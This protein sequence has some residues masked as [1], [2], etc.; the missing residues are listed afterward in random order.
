MS[1][2]GPVFSLL[3]K[4]GEG[5]DGI[6]EGLFGFSTFVPH[7]FPIM[8]LMCSQFVP[9]LFLSFFPHVLCQM[10]HMLSPQSPMC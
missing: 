10:F 4:N 9:H 2:Q 1:R 8:S 5:V 3:L 6:L 7:L